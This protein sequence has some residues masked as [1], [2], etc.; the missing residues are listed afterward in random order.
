MLPQEKVA[1]LDWFFRGSLQ[2]FAGYVLCG[3]KPMCIEAVP[4]GSESL[5]YDPCWYAKKEAFNTLRSWQSTK[6]HEY[7][8]LF[9]DYHNYSHML[10]INRRAFLKAVKE[11]L[12]LFLYVLGPIVEPESLLEEL[13][14]NQTTFWEVLKNDTALIGILLGYGPRNSLIHARVQF[15]NNCKIHSK[16]AIFPEICPS[17][18]PPTSLL[19][20]SLEEELRYL[21]TLHAG[22]REIKPFSSYEIPSFS[23]DPES[24]E[25]LALLST[26]EKNRASI[27]HMSQREDL[28]E[29]ML[30]KTFLLK[31]GKLCIP[32]SIPKSLS[33]KDNIEMLYLK[34]AEIIQTEFELQ[35]NFMQFFLL[36]M[37]DRDSQKPA[38]SESSL[39][40]TELMPIWLRCCK[41]LIF[42]NDFIKKALLDKTWR[43]LIPN[44]LLYKVLKSGEG[45]SATNKVKKVSFHISYRMT[46]EP[47]FTSLQSFK[48]VFISDLIPGVAHSLIGMKKGEMRRVIIHPRY[49]YGVKS[50]PEN[51]SMLAELHLIDFEEGDK[52]AD[53]KPLSDLEP[54][55]AIWDGV[56]KQSP[57]KP[58]NLAKMRSEEIKQMH[59]TLLKEDQKLQNSS[60]YT[61]G[62][63]FWD[64]IKSEH[65]GM[66]FLAFQKELV[67]KKKI[68]QTEDEKAEFIKSFK[69]D[70]FVKQYEVNNLP[71]FSNTWY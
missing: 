11:N 46:W 53:L 57:L 66:N 49:F 69:L 14:K 28:L 38:L 29:Q 50:S 33:R 41:N 43:S 7:I 30:K 22:S 65:P 62:Y 27:L 40:K 4:K 8:F 58:L 32:K 36:G 42:A 5:K 44:H 39:Y 35:K 61:Y 47:K 70:L 56:T 24:K 63:E 6:D 71:P 12:S 2:S 19:F 3:D 54:E 1:I 26:Y 60:Y 23:C 17:L 55:Y 25:T 13:I 31:S 51:A 68:F 10:I 52:E 20:S 45:V 18:S 37:K 48:D 21:Y 59:Q 34:F 15:L 16:T 64:K 67:S 9:P